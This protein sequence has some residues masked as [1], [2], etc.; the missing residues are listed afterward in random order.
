MRLDG[1]DDS[2]TGQCRFRPA[3][4]QYGAPVQEVNP[5]AGF[6]RKYDQPGSLTVDHEGLYRKIKTHH[7]KLESNELDDEDI[8]AE[9]GGLRFGDDNQKCK[10]HYGDDA[11]DGQYGCE[12]HRL[13]EP[14]CVDLCEALQDRWEELGKSWAVKLWMVTY[15]PFYFSQH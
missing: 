4:S 13:S 8:G 6:R 15:W 9:A 7:E 3:I 2:I 1:G 14:Y 10:I 12:L 5:G 11:G